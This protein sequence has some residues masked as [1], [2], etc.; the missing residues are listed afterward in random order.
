MNDETIITFGG[1]IKAVGSR[2]FMGHAVLFGG[3]D[4][5]G[6][7]FVPDC[8]LGLT[9]RVSLPAYWCHSLD[10]EIGNRKLADCEFKTTS[11][12]LFIRGA[13]NRLDKVEEDLLTAI[14]KGKLGFS[15]GSSPHLVRKRKR[16]SVVEITHW[17][18]SEISL[19]PK[20]VER[21]TKVLPL[22]SLGAVSLRPISA[23]DINQQA[24]NELL[25]F[26][27]L[28]LERMHQKFS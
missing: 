5:E 23:D 7:T 17:P 25:R 26:E 3:V 24:L 12:G 2:G 16:G 8:D 1:A 6:E 15:S 20:P 22:K 9:G 13:F 11:E 19:T 18:V 4:Q 14:H 10:P 27:W 21:R 28:R